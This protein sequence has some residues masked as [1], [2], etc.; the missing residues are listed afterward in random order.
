MGLFKEVKNMNSEQ[1]AEF[2]KRKQEAGRQIYLNN[3][4]A[5]TNKMMDAEAERFSKKIAELVESGLTHN[6][7]ETIVGQNIAREEARKEK[8]ALRRERQAE[9]YA[10]K[11]ESNKK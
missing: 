9:A 6:E 4:E 8:L 7:A 11:L 1:Q 5:V 2:R 10:K 3:L